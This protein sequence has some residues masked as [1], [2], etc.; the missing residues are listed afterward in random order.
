MLL[1]LL[2]TVAH[3]L[4]IARERK[5]IVQTRLAVVQSL[6]VEHEGQLALLSVLVHDE[7]RRLLHTVPAHHAPHRRRNL[8]QRL[9]QILVARQL[10][11]HA[12]HDVLIRHASL[13][14]LA[15]HLRSLM[16]GVRHIERE[17]LL[18]RVEHQRHLVAT[19]HQTYHLLVLRLGI[20]R[21]AHHVLTLLVERRLQF[22]AQ[23][24]QCRIKVFLLEHRTGTQRHAQHNPKTCHA[25]Q[26]S[27]SHNI[28]LYVLF[29]FQLCLCVQKYVFFLKTHNSKF[30]IRVALTPLPVRHNVFSFL[31]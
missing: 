14:E 12:L 21:V 24:R 3:V 5:R 22:G 26:E 7:L 10:R 16:A 28:S 23:H 9:Y 8:A 1:V 11:V 2:H 30:K 4:Q 17:V 15:V 6:P 20:H 19:L 13:A 29:I 25:L 31:F 27:Y 18:L